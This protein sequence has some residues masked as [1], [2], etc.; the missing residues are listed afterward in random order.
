MITDGA[1]SLAD[2]LLDLFNQLL[3]PNAIPPLAWKKS[4]VTVIYKADEPS[5]ADN[6]RPI[7][8]IPL[9]YKLFARLLYNRLEPVLAPQQPPDQAGFRHHYSTDDHLFTTTMVTERSQE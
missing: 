9:L 4:I 3:L 7:T 2:V 1:S 8:I 5:K 6:Y